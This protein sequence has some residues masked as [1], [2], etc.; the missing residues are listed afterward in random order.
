VRSYAIANIRLDDIPDL[1]KLEVECQ[2]SPWTIDAY[3]AEHGRSDSVM[4]KATDGDGN[5]CGFVIGRAPLEGGDAEIYNLGVSPSDRR[6]G[7][8]TMLMLEFRRIC[9]ERQIASIWLEVRA[10]NQAAIEFY[11]SHGFIQKGIRPKFYSDPPDDA[12][13]MSASVQ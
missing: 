5:V 3:E 8:A 1:K 7:I 11:L 2:L 13:L 12:I 10:A 6:Q 9:L 4:L